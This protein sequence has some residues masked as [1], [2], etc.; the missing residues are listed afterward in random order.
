MKSGH[1]SIPVDDVLRKTLL[2]S[3]VSGSA[4]SSEH[5]MAEVRQTIGDEF[6][7]CLKNLG[8]N[9]A[10]HREVEPGVVCSMAEASTTLYS[11]ID[12][13][14]SSATPSMHVPTINPTSPMSLAS[15]PSNDGN[16]GKASGFHISHMPQTPNHP[17]KYSRPQPRSQKN[18]HIPLCVV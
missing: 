1:P 13:V 10:L 6:E 11:I 15:T 3:P 12:L 18:L 16:D 7:K 8:I 2:R 9:S 4:T 17:H 14:T 5:S